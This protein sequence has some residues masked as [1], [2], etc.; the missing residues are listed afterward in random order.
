MNHERFG[1]CRIG[2]RPEVAHSWREHLKI[3]GITQAEGN[4][5]KRRGKEMYAEPSQW[6]AR[7]EAVPRDKWEAIQVWDGTKWVD[8]EDVVNQAA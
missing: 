7:F 2:V 4:R 1:C 3:S 6:Y 5:L 8:A